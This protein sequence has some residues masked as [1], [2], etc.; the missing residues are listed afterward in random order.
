[1]LVH[2]GKR[3]NFDFDFFRSDRLVC[4]EIVFRAFDGIENFHFRLQE[5][6]GRQTISAEDLLDMAIDSEQFAVKGIF[7]YPEE[8]SMLV[9]GDRARIELIRSYRPD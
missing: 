3:Y 9:R 2:S 4:T 6:A 8:S 1:M 7:G 5:R